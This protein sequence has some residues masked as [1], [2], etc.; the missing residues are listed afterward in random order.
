MSRDPR[1]RIEDAIEACEQI[2]LYIEGYDFERFS[3]DTKTRDA[4]IRQFEIAGEAVKG[5]P[6]SFR[7]L[8]PGI[9][10]RQIAGFRDVLSHSYFAVEL[11]I[12]W[13]AASLKAPD[14][15]AACERLLAS[16]PLSDSSA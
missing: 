7:S 10:W 9:P 8:E 2:A 11:H 5:V 15:K 1:Q 12:V 6:E 3:Q 13:D 4:V 16:P 14:L